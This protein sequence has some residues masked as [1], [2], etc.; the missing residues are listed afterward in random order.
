MQTIYKYPLEI[1]DKQEITILKGAK[2]LC[3]NFDGNNQLCLWVQVN[4]L[5]GKEEKTFYVVGTGNP[6]PEDEM[7]YIGSVKDNVTNKNTVFMWHI[8]IGK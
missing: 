5:A 7:E 3:V 4:D 2:P 8:F 6:I 1:T